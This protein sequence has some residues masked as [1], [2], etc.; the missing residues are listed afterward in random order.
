MN[1]FLFLRNLDDEDIIFDM[2][3]GAV[4]GNIVKLNSKSYTI[5][6]YEYDEQEDIK[7]I[8]LSLADELMADFNGYLSSTDSIDEEL[9]LI[10]TLDENIF[11][12]LN[13]L[14]SV[15]SYLDKGQIKGFLDFILKGTSID[16]SFIK[17]FALNDLNVS[18]ASKNMYIHRNTMNYKLDKLKMHSGFD[19]RKFT[20]AY[21]L[22][23]LILRK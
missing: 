18:K 9:K 3:S 1:R 21:L 5:Y 23:N 4:D 8:L 15:L 10:L 22:Y 2:L 17:D 12:G 6:K 11:V 16:E 19:L 7:N 14:K 20:D 13:D